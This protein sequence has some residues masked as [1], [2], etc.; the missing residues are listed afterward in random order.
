MCTAAHIME[1]LSL[2]RIQSDS[3][4]AVAA[5][6]VILLP[7]SSGDPLCYL[8]FLLASQDLP[9]HDQEF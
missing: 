1:A 7:D 2:S 3:A 5:K 4:D 8:A 6:H 9:C